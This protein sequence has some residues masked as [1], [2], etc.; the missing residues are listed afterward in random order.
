MLKNGCH[1]V[2]RDHKWGSII[3][4]LFW[5]QKESLSQFLAGKS[6]SV[7]RHGISIVSEKW[8][9]NA[10]CRGCCLILMFLSYRPILC[11]C[12]CIL[13]IWFLILTHGAR[14]VLQPGTNI[15]KDPRWVQLHFHEIFGHEMDSAFLA[16][17]GLPCFCQAFQARIPEDKSAN[18]PAS[19]AEQ[20][21][22]QRF[23]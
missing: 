22:K 14:P 4:V 1:I 9:A 17:K 21:L 19:E 13:M 7:I 20:D 12:L 3:N 16:C 10:A 8:Q 5:C 15:G 18:Q 11:N 6:E 23:H 2:D